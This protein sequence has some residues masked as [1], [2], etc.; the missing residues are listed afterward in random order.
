MRVMV[1][2]RVLE[3]PEGRK[4]GVYGRDKVTLRWE[5][6]RLEVSSSWEEGEVCWLTQGSSRPTIF[7]LENT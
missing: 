7:L 3:S 6:E 5:G 2:G 4:A 1:A